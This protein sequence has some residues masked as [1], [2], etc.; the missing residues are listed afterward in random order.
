MPQTAEAIYL[1]TTFI[2]LIK[3][4]HEAYYFYNC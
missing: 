4:S 2:A 3:R 1:H